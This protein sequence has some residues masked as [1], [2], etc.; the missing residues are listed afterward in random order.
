MHL[1]VHFW[2]NLTLQFQL[3][4]KIFLYLDRTFLASSESI[5]SIWEMA[6]TLLMHILESES[7][8]VLVEDAVAAVLESIH[9]ERTGEKTERE[10]IR[11]VLEMLNSL[12]LYSQELETPLFSESHSFYESESAKFIETVSISDY[13]KHVEKRLSDESERSASLLFETPEKALLAVVE[14]EM[15]QKHVETLLG[16]EFWDLLDRNAIDD[17]YRLYFL[18]ARVN[19]LEPVKRAYSEYLHQ[20]GKDFILDEANDDVMVEKM[21]SL[22]R[23]NDTFIVK[24]FGNNVS[25]LQA[26]RDTFKRFINERK[27]APA[28]YIAKYF[29]KILRAGN[30]IYSEESI[31]TLL[32]ELMILFRYINGKDVFEA[33][34]KKDLA[35][36]LLLNQSASKEFEKLAVSKL[37]EECGKSFTKKLEGM[38]TDMDVSVELETNFRAFKEQSIDDLPEID[39]NI[40]VLTMGNWPSYPPFE[41]Y[42]PPTVKILQNAFVE[43]Y[44]GLAKHNGRK[45]SWQSSLAHCELGVRFPSGKKILLVSACQAAI[46]LQFNSIYT[47]TFKQLAELTLLDAALLKLNLHSLLSVKILQKKSKTDEITET[48]IFRVNKKFSSKQIRIRVNEV[49]MKETVCFSFRFY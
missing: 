29:D 27:S 40:N 1:L 7:C 31:S 22:K 9:R 25:F 49:Q 33:F 18:L 48:D 10:N 39:L 37:C 21:L 14:E 41:I 46:L 3:I 36:R 2:K 15:V 35:K 17:L 11:V 28:E 24:A 26:S 23:R 16:Q 34:Y 38:F 47:A 13:L 8:R 19:A 4:R 44:L 32:D 12:N 45:I 43:F 5:H 20:R 6:L 30:T 42:I